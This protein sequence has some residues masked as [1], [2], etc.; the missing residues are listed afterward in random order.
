MFSVSSNRKPTETDFKIRDFI[1]THVRSPE[2]RRVSG[3]L[4]ASLNNV[5]KDQVLSIPLLWRRQWLRFASG[6]L[7]SLF[8]SGCKVSGHHIQLQQCPEAWR[9]VSSCLLTR[10]RETFLRSSQ[11]LSCYISEKSHIPTPKLI[12]GKNNTMAITGVE[13]WR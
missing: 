3:Q 1:F 2:V 7:P 10:I 9:T 12:T 13:Q 11:E 8:Q 6:T 4:I 5:I